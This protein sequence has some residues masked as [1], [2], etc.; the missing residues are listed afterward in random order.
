[1]KKIAGKTIEQWQKDL[2]LLKTMM[3][4]KPVF[5]CNPQYQA[6]STKDTAYEIF[7]EDVADADARLKRFAPYIAQVYPETR[8]AQGIIESPLQKI[9]NMQ[10]HLSKAAGIPL[11]GG[12]W[13]KCD[14]LLAISGSIKARG[15]IYE[16]LKTAETMAMNQGLLKLEDDYTCLDSDD[17]KQFFSQYAIAVGSTGNLGLSIGIMGAQMGFKVYVHM[18]A[19]AAL[20]KKQRLKACGVEVIEYE[21]DYSSAV[22]AGRRQAQADPKMHFVDDE[23]SKD[24]LLG[25]AVAAQ[26]LKKQ[27]AFQGVCVDKDHPLFVYLPCGVGGGPGG[28]TLGLKLIFGD[29]VHCFFAEPTQS[30]CMLLGLMTGL[31]DKISVRDIGLSNCTDADGLAVGRPSGFV[32]KTLG[33]VISGSY[34]V[35]DAALY[36]LLQAMADRESIFLEPSAAAGLAGPTSLLRNAEDASDPVRHGLTSRGENATHLVW[37]TGGGM[38]PESVMQGYYRHSC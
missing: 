15:G 24:L 22:A 36:Q 37:A 8:A 16:V 7:R 21:S 34:T 35:A 38:V 11:P 17:F 29:C 13:A 1:M 23:N 33:P 6:D 9:P 18:S 2:P 30:P 27:L 31:H 26:R 3:D 28:I 10:R 5:W 20:W 14:N 25:Y 4:G 12:L 32:G 19:D